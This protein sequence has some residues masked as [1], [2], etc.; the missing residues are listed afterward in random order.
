MW[1]ISCK[2]VVELLLYKRFRK[3]VKVEDAKQIIQSE[4]YKNVSAI[5]RIDLKQPKFQ[6]TFRDRVSPKSQNF[7]HVRGKFLIFR[8][9]NNKQ[10]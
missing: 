5:F 4:V 10:K 7:S 1:K 8:V 2:L 9:L 3:E 6:E